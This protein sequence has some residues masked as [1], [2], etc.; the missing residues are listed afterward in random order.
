MIVEVKSPDVSDL[1]LVDLPGIIHDGDSKDKIENMIIRYIESKYSL[2]MIVRKANQDKETVASINLARKYDPQ[3]ERTIEIISQCDIF[4]SDQLKN[5][6][7]Q[8]IKSESN[9]E[10]GVHA[11]CCRIKGKETTNS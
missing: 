9:Q 11:V 1:T 4:S 7:K 8:L 10:L 3:S 2:I 6:I 5:H